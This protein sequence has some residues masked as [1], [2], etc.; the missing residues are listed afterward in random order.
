[1]RISD[2]SSD[3]CSSDLHLPDIYSP[4]REVKSEAERQAINSPVQ[5][6]ASDLI[7]VSLVIAH[8]KFREMGLR[9]HSIGTV[10]DAMIME[11]PANEMS[12][13]L[14]MVKEIMDN[15]PLEEWFGIHMSVPLV[16]DC[17][18]G[19]HWGDAIE[20]TEQIGSAH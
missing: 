8:K 15:P 16:A 11:V 20:L 18:V 13:V 9:A 7:L 3:V 19:Q 2:W 6:F 10:H 1:M 4:D 14:P 12:T 5:S 17:K